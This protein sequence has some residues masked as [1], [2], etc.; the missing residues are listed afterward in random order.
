MV[1]FAAETARDEAELIELGTAKL[2]R[3]GC[4]LL[5]LN[6]VSDGAVF[7]SGENEVLLIAPV[8]SRGRAAGTKTTV[9]HAILHAAIAERSAE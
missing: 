8:G 6:N 3:K 7:G 5:V 2:A 1:G 9:A 4:Q